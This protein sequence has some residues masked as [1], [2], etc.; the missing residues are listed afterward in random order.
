[1]N[2]LRQR[3]MHDHR[4]LHTVL[5][6]LAEDADAPQVGQLQQTWARFERHL[7]AHLEAEEQLLLALLQASYP[8]EVE[9]TRREHAKIR[10]LVSEL[11]VA[12]E[13]HTV[14][15][16][17]ILALVRLLDEHAEREDR[18]LYDLAGE[19]ASV[20]VEHRLA[21]LIKSSLA[22][23]RASSLPAR[24]ARVMP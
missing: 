5:Q 21:T 24:P 13:L 19:R 20:A 7:L 6:Q 2:A 15:K 22:A 16:E 8:E 3:L 4:E 9:R 1:M 14:R 18:G 10:E 17:A 23:V 11:G 12:V